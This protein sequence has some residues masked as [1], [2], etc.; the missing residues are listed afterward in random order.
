MVN[1][2]NRDRERV[3]QGGIF[4]ST[5][6]RQTMR[7]MDRCVNLPARRGY[8]DVARFRQQQ[9]EWELEPTYRIVLSDPANNPNSLP[10]A[11]HPDYENEVRRLQEETAKGQKGRGKDLDPPWRRQDNSSRSSDYVQQNTDWSNWTAAPSRNERA[12]SSSSAPNWQDSRAGWINRNEQ[13]RPTES[14][15]NNQNRNNYWY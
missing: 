13:T 9:T 4:P 8:L 7:E 1:A 14:S 3:R 12:S 6:G 10:A 15:W 5:P 2:L 11:N